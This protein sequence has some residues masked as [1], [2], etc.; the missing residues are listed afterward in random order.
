MKPINQKI[1]ADL[2]FNFQAHPVTH[3]LRVRTNIEAIKQ[4]IK[5]L[6][7]TNRFEKPF[8]PTY[9]GNIKASLFENLDT[10]DI[11]ALRV[12]VEVVIQNYEPRGQVLDIT[13][14]DDLDH[15]G[16]K[17]SIT[18]LPT[19]SLTPVAIDLFLQRVR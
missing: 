10:G 1:Y 8:K 7:L 3:K 14:S 11:A 4:A 15:N 19:T 18:F 13:V 5:N 6:V 17:M 16:Y 9:G 2:D 12:G